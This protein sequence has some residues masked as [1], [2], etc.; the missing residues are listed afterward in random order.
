MASRWRGTSARSA[1]AAHLVERALGEFGR[2]DILVNNAAFQMTHEGI[3]DL[4]SEEVER[5]FRTNV[6]A[7]FHLCQAALRT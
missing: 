1:T 5:T 4:P 2:L 7:M 6:F 3:A